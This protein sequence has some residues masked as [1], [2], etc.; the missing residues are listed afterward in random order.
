MSAAAGL[1]M[2]SVLESDRGLVRGANE[3]AHGQV[4]TPDGALLLVV[5]D[6][7]G[8]HVA[9]DVASQMAVDVI[10]EI[11][12]SSRAGPEALLRE[13]IREANDRILNRG[14]REP[15][16]AGMGTTVVALLLCPDGDAWTAHVGDS[17][18]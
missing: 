15:E 18:A 4:A 16:V 2:R 8:G 12:A 17:R 3:D 14:S 5:A 7:V 1:R 6:G 11:A 9:G 13:A 10:L